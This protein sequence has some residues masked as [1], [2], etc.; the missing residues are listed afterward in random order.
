MRKRC[1]KG[2]PC[3]A[4]CIDRRETCLK[5]AAEPVKEAL[6]SFRD[7]LRERSAPYSLSPSVMAKGYGP[8]QGPVGVIQGSIKGILNE[9][10]KEPDSQKV[11]GLVKEKDINW[12]EVLRGGVKY[13]GGGD[14]GSFVV[15]ETD[16]LL[17]SG[18]QGLR[19]EVGVKAG[20]IGENEIEALKIVGANDLGPKFI[21]A[22]VSTRPEKDRGGNN[23]YSGVIA[24]SK[25]PAISYRRTSDV[26]GTLG[27]KSDMYWR[28]MADLHRLG[29]AHN[30]MHGNNVMIDS[31][32]KARFIDFGLSQIS[33]KAALAEALGSLNYGNWQFSASQTE[34]LARI[35][36]SNMR[37]VERFL[38]SK[39][40]DSDDISNIIESGI[41]NKG[42][43]YQNGAWGKI[44]DK[45]AKEAIRLFYDGIG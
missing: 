38:L 17:P 27:T 40:L 15:M 16:K 6:G 11:D 25:V 14:Y 33:A 5:D 3:G 19:R 43:F 10:Q 8:P 29:I 22:R 30:D 42:D 31:L 37:R 36:Q 2:K 13:I 21:G 23:V 28:A 32:G 35:A 4:T 39:G 1:E 12:K 18:R 41:R 26:V 9:L 34:G 45:E 24:M 20:R 7:S 44:T